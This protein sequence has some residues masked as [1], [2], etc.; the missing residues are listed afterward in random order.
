LLRAFGPLGREGPSRTFTTRFCAGLSNACQILLPRPLPHGF[1]KRPLSIGPLPLKGVLPP[2]PP[3]LGALF[4]QQ[5]HL[6]HS[7]AGLATTPSCSAH[8]SVLPA[9]RAMPGAHPCGSVHLVL[10]VNNLVNTTTCT[11]NEQSSQGTAAAAWLLCSMCAVA[12][13]HC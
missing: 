6:D 12:S 13:Q 2:P 10:E 1:M 8:Y 4:Y 9:A 5:A 7:T 3:S 11:Q